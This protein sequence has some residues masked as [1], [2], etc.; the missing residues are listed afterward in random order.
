[1]RKRERENEEEKQ[2][3]NDSEEEKGGRSPTHKRD[4]KRKS[5]EKESK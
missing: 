1:M 4:E 2:F 3:R 5:N